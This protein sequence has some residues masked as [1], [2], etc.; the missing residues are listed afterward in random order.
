MTRTIQA[1]GFANCMPCKRAGQYLTTFDPDAYEGLKTAPR[2]RN[3][4]EF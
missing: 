4:V 2:R 3:H 1:V